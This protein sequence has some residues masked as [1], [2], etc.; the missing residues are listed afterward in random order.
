MAA[1]VDQ[2]YVQLDPA[3]FSGLIWITPRLA[4]SGDVAALDVAL[5]STRGSTPAD[6]MVTCDPPLA[7]HP[8][9]DGDASGA[10]HPWLKLPSAP[11]SLFTEQPTGNIW[12]A[13][14]GTIERMDPRSQTV[15]QTWSTPTTDSEASSPGDAVVADV[16]GE[17][18]STRVGFFDRRSAT[19]W[20]FLRQPDGSYIRGEALAAYPLSDRLTR[21]LTA[22]FDPQAGLFQL[23]DYKGDLL[24]SFKSMVRFLGPTGSLFAMVGDDGTLSVLRGDELTLMR[25]PTSKTATAVASS[26]RLL[27]VATLQPMTVITAYRLG[28][29]SVWEYAWSSSPMANPVSALC[30][31]SVEGRPTL[32]AGLGGNES[33]EIVSIR[34]PQAILSN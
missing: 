17:S 8:H 1:D 29:D 4:P 19:G 30:V 15:L 13:W 27:F 7:L 23:T 10:F 18:D 3:T 14:R 32:L 21:F 31:G 25:G 20:W 22:P 16:G 33:G 24:G 9:A 6:L 2:A 12:I 34:L 11:A 5:R 26:G 28:S